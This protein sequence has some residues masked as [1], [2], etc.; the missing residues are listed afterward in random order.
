MLNLGCFMSSASFSPS[1][2]ARHFCR[3][4]GLNGDC[5]QKY[6]NLLRCL[7]HFVEYLNLL[8]TFTEA[9]AKRATTIQR[10]PKP[11]SKTRREGEPFQN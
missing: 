1:K 2:F 3:M 8:L 4:T 6:Q 5:K 10:T 9:N 11:H 7:H